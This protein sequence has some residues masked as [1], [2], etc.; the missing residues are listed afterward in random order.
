MA[1]TEHVQQFVKYQQRKENLNELQPIK[2]VEVEVEMVRY[3]PA[4]Q[5]LIL[6]KYLREFAGIPLIYLNGPAPAFE[7]PSKSTQESAEFKNAQKLEVTGYQK[8]ILNR[9]KDE[10][11]NLLKF[12]L[13]FFN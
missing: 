4:T 3:I 8:E 9:M 1:K 11:I 13:V 2:D 12:F 6:R 10:V 7:R 5:D